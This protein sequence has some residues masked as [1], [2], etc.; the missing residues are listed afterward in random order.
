MGAGYKPIEEM[1]VRVGLALCE[2]ATRDFN[3]FSDDPETAK[4]DK[5]KVDGGFEA[6]VGAVWQLSENTLLTSK[7]GIF[8]PLKELG[9]TSINFDNIYHHG[10]GGKILKY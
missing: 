5:F 10:Q 9:D 8:G 6:A 7:L 1:Q 4:V 3:G 2:I